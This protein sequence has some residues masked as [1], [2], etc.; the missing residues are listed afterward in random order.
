MQY[1]SVRN[2][3]IGE[4]KKKRW[5]VIRLQ[6]YHYSQIRSSLLYVHP[7]SRGWS[8]EIE[9]EHV[10]YDGDAETSGNQHFVKEK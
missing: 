6:D 9:I 2:I 10:G 5:R 4:K 3:Y 1:E 8:I 7:K